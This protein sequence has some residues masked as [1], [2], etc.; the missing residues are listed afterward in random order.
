VIAEG[1]HREL[2]DTEPRYAH[3]VVREDDT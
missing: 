1:N 3:T 2:L